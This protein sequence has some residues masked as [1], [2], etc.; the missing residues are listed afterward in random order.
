[1][2]LDIETFLMFHSRTLKAF[3]LPEAAKENKIFNDRTSERK[4][5]ESV[6]AEELQYDPVLLK[7]DDEI[8]FGENTCL[9]RKQREYTITQKKNWTSKFSVFECKGWIW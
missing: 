4:T 9:N 2:L 7:A 8:S 1:M 5:V 3:A 6:I